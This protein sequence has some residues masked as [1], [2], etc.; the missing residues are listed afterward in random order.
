MCVIKILN[1]WAYHSTVYPKKQGEIHK[2]D[3]KKYAVVEKVVERAS[4][5]KA[6]EE[7]GL[8]QSGVS[9]IVAA[10][11]AELG[12]PLLKRTRTGAR[13]TPEGERIMP[14][15]RAIVAEERLLR[16]T[17]EALHTLV[18]GKVRVGTFTSVATH[19]LPAMMMQFWTDPASLCK[20]L[21]QAS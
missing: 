18:A 3:T 2:M 4:L 1:A 6:A 16:Q 10:V 11:E 12:L 5:T 13:L 19:W 21:P 9:H 7:L 20:G 14:H 8:T 15:I 17:A